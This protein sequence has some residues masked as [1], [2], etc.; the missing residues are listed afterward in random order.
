MATLVQQIDDLKR[1][2]KSLKMKVTK[3]TNGKKLEAKYGD[4]AKKIKDLEMQLTASTEH[5][6]VLQQLNDELQV[7]RTDLRIEISNFQA[8]IANTAAVTVWKTQP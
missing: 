5:V 8:I 3:L 6:D 2:N 7:E 4:Q 1:E